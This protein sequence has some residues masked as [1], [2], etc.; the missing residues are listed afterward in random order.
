MRAESASSMAGS[1]FML[2]WIKLRPSSAPS[3]TWRHR[4]V[5]QV[6]FRTWPMLSCRRALAFSRM[7]DR[8]H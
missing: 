1:L 8:G 4:K 3:A 5:L 7:R 2:K 6:C